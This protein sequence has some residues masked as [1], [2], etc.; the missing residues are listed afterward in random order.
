[1]PMGP[2]STFCV[3]EP[4]S[5]QEI[6]I[7]LSTRLV[8]STPRTCREYYADYDAKHENGHDIVARGHGIDECVDAA[9]Q[10]Q[11][12]LLQ[13]QHNSHDNIGRNGR[14]DQTGK[15]MEEEIHFYR[16]L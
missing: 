10:P 3:S 13:L 6:R 7:K 9:V 12:I 4:E 11:T 1:M 15:V 2:C 16:S 8:W 14:N 5:M